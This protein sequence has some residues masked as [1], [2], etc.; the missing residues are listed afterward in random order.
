MTERHRKCWF[1]HVALTL[2]LMFLPIAEISSAKA[3]EK[4]SEPLMVVMDPLAKELACACVKGYG[5]RD[6]RKLAAKLGA[7]LKQRVAIEFSDDLADTL[8]G[9]DSAREVIIIGDRSLV[10]HDAKQTRVACHSVCELSDID[11]NTTLSAAFVVRATDPAKELKDITGRKLLFGLRDVDAKHVAA[12]AALRSAGVEIS[13]KPESRAVYTD[14]A[15]DM[16]DSSA[17]PRPVAVLPSYGPR[18]L[19]GCGS[20]KPGEL[21][22]IGKTEPQPFITAFLS[23]NIP[24]AKEQE[25]LKALLSIKDDPKLLEAMESRD[26]F[27]VISRDLPRKVSADWPDWRGPNR[28]GR[29]PQLP[30]RLPEQTKFI[31]KRA[32]VN[33]GLAGL[34][35]SGDRLLVAERDL[36]DEPDVYRCLNSATGELLWRKQFLARGTLD[37]GQAPRATPVIRDE[38]AYLLGAFGDLRCLDMNDGRVIWERKLPREFNAELPT[39]G[40]CSTPLLVN[41]LVIV[42]PGAT[43]AS[44]A[45][46]DART[47]R[48]RWTTPGSPAAYAGFIQVQREGRSQIVGYDR[49]SLG[50]WDMAGGKRLWRVV[51]ETEGDFNVPTPIAFDNGIIVTTE[52]NGTR[53]YSFDPSGNLS[54]KPC[55]TFAGLAPDSSTPVVTR[56]R[57]FGAH[58]G[59]HCLDARDGLKP[60]WNREDETIGD[61]ATLIADDERVLVITVGGELILLDARADTCSIISRMRVFAEDVEVYSHPALVGTRLFIRGGSSV[62][63]VDLGT[64][65]KELTTK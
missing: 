11:G 15:L 34:S 54:P 42:N 35:V 18:L 63:C 53:I 65:D 48:T 29:V 51:P 13:G 16:L 43:N 41:D 6:Y 49:H 26:G 64:T 60:V 58:R 28:D 5:Q 27:K 20:V 57:V 24:A 19:Q 1:G 56:G 32:A 31:W 21:R 3:A 36:G 62:A 8:N 23:D 40:A 44:L 45:A 14:A 38:R 50:G 37:Y 9:I 39:W 7:T 17:T 59:L 30:A 12:L 55:G 10:T 22:V 25:I 33:G 47:G 46:L 2:A 61:Y 52:N 4:N